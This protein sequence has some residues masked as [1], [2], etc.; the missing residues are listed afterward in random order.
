MVAESERG[1]TRFFLRQSALARLN[2]L[3]QPEP[4]TDANIA[5][6]SSRHVEARLLYPVS[7]FLVVHSL[8][9]LCRFEI[10]LKIR[11]DHIDQL[12]LPN[13][14]KNYLQERQYYTE[15]VQAYLNS[16]DSFATEQD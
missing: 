9:H 16:V 7:R 12:P 8:A 3:P 6:S 11:R 13:H 15:F 1:Q 2:P 5:E 4:S 14:L 10:L